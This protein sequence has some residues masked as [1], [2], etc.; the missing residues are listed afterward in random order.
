MKKNRLQYFLATQ[1]LGRRAK[2]GRSK[3]TLGPD[4]SLMRV[5]FND[6]R[7][8]GSVRVAVVS[9]YRVLGDGFNFRPRRL[10]FAYRG[11]STRTRQTSAH[12]GDFSCF[13]YAIFQCWLLSC[14]WD[15][16]L[17]D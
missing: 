1:H 11:E 5:L 15:E 9:G 10:F 17:T 2:R 16:R 12:V 6:T 14:I 8:G 7:R 13:K 3:R 4:K